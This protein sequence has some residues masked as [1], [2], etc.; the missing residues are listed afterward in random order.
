M[1]TGL[2]RVKKYT[3][4]KAP[5]PVACTVQCLP[6]LMVPPKF[7]EMIRVFTFPSVPSVCSCLKRGHGWKCLLCGGEGGNQVQMQRPV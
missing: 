1:I 4:L 2:G 7:E 5:S 6:G 3:N